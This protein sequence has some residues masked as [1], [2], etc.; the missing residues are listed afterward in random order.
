MREKEG[1]NYPNYTKIKLTTDF[2]TVCH[3]CKI[4][5]TGSYPQ[6]AHWN[7]QIMALLLSSSRYR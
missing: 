3:L 4:S 2:V 5:T 1:G 6:F 7:G